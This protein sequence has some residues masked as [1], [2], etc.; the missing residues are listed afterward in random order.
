MGMDDSSGPVFLQKKE[1]VAS[2]F[3][4]NP[5]EKMTPANPAENEGD[6]QQGPPL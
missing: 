4:K 6:T 3:Q 1:D 5:W 2:S